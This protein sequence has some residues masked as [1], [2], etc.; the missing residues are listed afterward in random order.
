[1]FSGPLF[2]TVRPGEQRVELDE[3]EVCLLYRDSM[4]L[5]SQFMNTGRWGGEPVFESFYFCELEQE[6]AYLTGEL[7][8]RLVMV[9][10][11]VECAISTPPTPLTPE[12]TQ[13]MWRELLETEWESHLG[14]WRYQQLL[15]D[16]VEQELYAM[17]HEQDLELQNSYIETYSY[18]GYS[19]SSGSTH[20]AW[21]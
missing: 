2:Q 19:R 13:R 5:E 11:E 16:Q 6:A 9:D 20:S 8:R 7:S 3:D 17:Q 14:E 15:S 18:D 21:S 1:M 4:E 10:G 12:T